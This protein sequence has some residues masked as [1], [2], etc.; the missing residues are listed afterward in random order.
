M[1]QIL[2]TVVDRLLLILKRVIQEILTLSSVKQIKSGMSISGDEYGTL[3][4]YKSY[5]ADIRN[6]IGTGGG[7]WKRPGNALMVTVHKTIIFRAS[8][9]MLKAIS[10][11]RP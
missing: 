3:N 1:H 9:T 7:L 4:D 5:Y 11:A 2:T 6:Q 8:L 10:P